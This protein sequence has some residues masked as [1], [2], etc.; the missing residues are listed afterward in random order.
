[1]TD[2]QNCFISLIRNVVIGIDLPKDFKLCDLSE[3]YKLSKKQDMAHIIAFG[4]K[5]NKLIDVNSVLWK[6]YYNKQYSLSQF[7]VMNLEYEC[8]RV[9]DTF[10]EEKI[11]Y[12]P[13]KGAVIRA[14]Y[15]EPWMRVSCDIDIL[16]HKDQLS[17]VEEVLSQKLGYSKTRD[18]VI[19][20]HHHDNFSTPNG[21]TIELHFSLSEKDT[22]AKSFLDKVWENTKLADNYKY[23]Y[24]MNDEMLYFYHIYHAAHH[25]KGGGCG[26][27][28]VLDTWLILNS[29][30][31]V[32]QDCIDM[33]EAAQLTGFSNAIET[34]AK[35]WFSNIPSEKY[36]DVEDYIL[37]GGVQ[38]GGNSV[39]ARQSSIK[40]GR[41]KYYIQRAFPTYEFMRR[42]YPQLKRFPIL[43]PYY[44]SKRIFAAL[45]S[46]KSKRTKAEIKTAWLEKEKS[47]KIKAMFDE[48][49][50]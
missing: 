34:I 9:C 46:K 48:L 24:I 27:K 23:R 22:L 26:V 29:I 38:G 45:G 44:W 50:L 31:G 13:L 35:K 11:A 42:E 18:G 37:N 28:S 4:L 16:V 5:K 33:L 20:E 40:G 7:R 30:K 25:F 43:L 17:F 41:M 21:F 47:K 8:E 36:S 2:V 1:M 12:V 14:L 6:K 15:P 32:S 19:K 49:G 3:L 10:E 39:A